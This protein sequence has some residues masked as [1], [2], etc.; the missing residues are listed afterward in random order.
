M[1]SLAAGLAGGAI[2][3]LS[4]PDHLAAVAP[5][6]LGSRRSGLLAGLDWGVGHGAGVALVGLLAILARDAIPIHLVSRWSELM[7]GFL[8]LGVAGWAFYNGYRSLRAGAAPNAA[9][10]EHQRKRTATLGVGALHGSAGA[11]HLIGI[12]PATGLSTTG[13]VTYLAAYFVGAMLA[14][15]LIG[16]AAGELS[17]RGGVKLRPLMMFGA[18]TVAALVGSGWIVT[19]WPSA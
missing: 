13:A 15:A 18:A 3:A 14:M 9:A 2:H 19:S 16:A 7:V 17:A 10:H 11:S 1:L 8:L 6:S 12:L 5:L 4:G